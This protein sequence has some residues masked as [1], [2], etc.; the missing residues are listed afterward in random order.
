MGLFDWMTVES[1]TQK[2][3]DFEKAK[4]RLK[5]SRPVNRYNKEGGESSVRMAYA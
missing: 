4:E 3:R 5:I 2:K 1:E